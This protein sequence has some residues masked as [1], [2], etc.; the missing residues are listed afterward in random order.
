MS[1]TDVEA[2]LDAFVDGEL[3]PSISVDVARHAGQCASCDM[4]VR[5]MVLLRDAL[6]GASERAVAALDLS[7]VWPHVESEIVRGEQQTAWRDRVAGRR[8]VSRGVVW[9]T[10]AAMA[11]GIALLVR[12]TDPVST[13]GPIG[14]VASVNRVDKRLPNHVYIDRLAGKDI[15]LRRE[16]KSGTTM[17]WVNHEV[18][19]SGW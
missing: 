18:E 4:I 7:R 2:L 5:D 19:S 14:K 3:S 16:P 10:I 13:P 17:I 6:V 15:A 1:C 11:A 9:G 8:R 12:P